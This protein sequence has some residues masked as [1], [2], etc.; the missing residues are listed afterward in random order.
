[1]TAPFDI[2]GLGCVALDDLLYVAA[3]PPPDT[4]TPVRRR[5]R[6]CGGLTATALVAAVRLGCR[7]A[8][9]GTL[10]DDD[11][12][13][14]VLD[15]LR[16]EGIDVSFVRRRPGARPIHSLIIVD[17]S[18]QTRTIFYDV[19]N[20]LGAQPDWPDE[21]LIRSARVLFVDHWGIEGMLRAARL[22]READI[23]V[24]ADFENDQ[25][26][27]F[28]E[29]L[30]LADHLIVSESFAHQLTG[31]ALPRSAAE[32]LWA[33]GRS[34]VVVTCGAR[35]CWY[36][37]PNPG[38]GPTHQKA[39]AVPVMDTTGCGDVFHGAYAAA[40]AEGHELPKRVRFA[41]AAAAL[42]ATRRGGQA[43]IPTRSAVHAFLKEHDPWPAKP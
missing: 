18:R 28:A 6:Q 41:A 25:A 24:V 3:Y 34:A 35:G 38:D 13:D 17:E 30:N 29:L 40:L 21:Q 4:K 16:Q 15:R 22:A 42:K 8:Y 32:R 1:M 23:P 7:C 11:L 12:S 26:P 31:D 43:G 27:G 14:F 9:A 39:Y 10:G 33:A 36:L 5:E 37:G 2:L 20:V 19:H